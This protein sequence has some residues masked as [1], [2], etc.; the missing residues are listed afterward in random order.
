MELT[1]LETAVLS[2]KLAAGEVSAVEVMKATLGRI[3]Q[4]N[5]SVNAI[6]SLRAEKDLL[7]EAEAA[8]AAKPEGWLHGIPIAIKDLAD[9]AGLPTS[10]GSPLFAD[11]A[12]ARDST[13]TARL[14]AAGAIVIGKTNT[15]EFG[16]GSHTFNPVHGATRNPY[17]TTRSAG[18]SSGG[19]AAALAC[20][21]LT[22]ADGS[23][24]MGSLRNPA[25]WNNVYG[26]RPSWGLVPG[27]PDGDLYLHPLST[28]GPMARTPRDLAALLDV[29]AGPDAGRPLGRIA[30]PA[31]PGIDDAPEGLRGAW[32][33]D[34]DGALPFEDGVLETCKAALP[35][36][37][38]IGW[39]IEDIGAPFDADA[40]WRSWTTLRSFS[41]A[42]TLGEI[43]DDPLQRE[44]LKP[45][46]RWEAERGR[47]LSGVE[48]QAAS[49]TRSDWYRC[50]ASLFERFDVLIAP[51]A[52]V[53]PFPVE[54]EYPVRI[55]G[56][57]MDTYHRWM[58]VVIPASLIGLP[59]V[60]IPV[61]F[62]RQGLPMGAQ[63]IGRPGSDA[64][65]LRAAQAWHAATGWPQKRPAMV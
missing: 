53:W 35:Q 26:M 52:Q 12:A 11:V 3:E 42:N 51:S 57:E 48:I 64:W 59:V 65:L 18:G 44:K 17:D 45:S 50:A 19:A 10:Q 31:R 33:G 23:D 16:L 20:G 38:K 13:V 54:D 39:S 56:R 27:D 60:A 4:V 28:N 61:G 32:L 30:D 40:L 46:A 8:D 9:A 6:V 14:R 21:M 1:G 2:E 41:V 43:Y 37:R 36:M 63:L 62:G 29:M 7:K 22:V 55:A 25:A 5:G 24:M 47:A 58:E 15:P 34:W 49:L